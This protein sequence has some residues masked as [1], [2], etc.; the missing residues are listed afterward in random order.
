LIFPVLSIVATFELLDFQVKSRLM[1]LLGETETLNVALA[2]IGHFKAVALSLT[3][4]TGIPIVT[5][6]T[7][8]A[9]MFGFD[10]EAQVIV[11]LPNPIALTV[12]VLPTMAT[13]ESL[14][15]HVKAYRLRCLAEQLP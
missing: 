6:I 1:A 7:Q 10:F 3:D 5:V 4:V 12:P 15:L 11:A 8:A 14:E 13:L 2:P 9:L